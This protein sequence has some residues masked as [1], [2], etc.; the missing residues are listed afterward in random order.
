MNIR[1]VIRIILS[2]LIIYAVSCTNDNHKI[3]KR[4]LIPVN[5]LVPLLTDLYIGDG[6]LQYPGVRDKFLNKDTI[7]SYLDII[8]KHGYTKEKVDKTLQY[9]FV[10]D[11]K[12]LQ[13]IYDMALARLSEI[14]SRAETEKAV[15][16][17][18]DIWDQK[19]SFTVP[20]EGTNN[21]IYFNIPIRDTGFYSLTLT[22]I[23]YKN[24][25]SINPRITV[26]FWKAD[27]AGKQVKKFW[28]KV[29][30]VKDDLKHN[31]VAIGRVSDTSF[32]HI[33]GF[34]LDG[35]PQNGRWE[36]HAK[37]NDIKLTKG[38]PE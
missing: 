2:L 33:S 24:D 13:K 20:D 3:R 29:D 19:T 12:K 26:F 32:K 14:Q 38:P 35:D 1:P 6:L 5:E 15:Q 22:A 36:K 16:V 8:K 9:Y 7:S 10:N 4:D 27:S 11:S 30:L 23:I 18:N 34:L 28:D 25:Q 21:S 31:Y 17:T 37:I